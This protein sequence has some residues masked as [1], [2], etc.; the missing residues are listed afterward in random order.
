MYKTLH[1]AGIVHNKVDCHVLVSAQESDKE[2]G[3]TYRLTGF[4]SYILRGEAGWNEEMTRERQVLQS[5]LRVGK[6]VWDRD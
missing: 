4:D 5:A 3:E 6:A 1:R 2:Q